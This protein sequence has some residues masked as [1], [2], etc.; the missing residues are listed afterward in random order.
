MNHFAC[1]C[2]QC[3]GVRV[4]DKG[5]ASV[6]FQKPGACYMYLS[7]SPGCDPVC[8]FLCSNLRPVNLLFK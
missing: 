2:T 5:R 1:H 4:Q 8:A 3:P 6:E 7:C